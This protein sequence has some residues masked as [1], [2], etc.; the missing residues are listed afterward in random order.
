LRDGLGLNEVLAGETIGS[1]LANS[2]VVGVVTAAALVVGAPTATVSGAA[3]PAAR[4][5]RPRS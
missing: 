1:E 4:R 5:R 3:W 2:F